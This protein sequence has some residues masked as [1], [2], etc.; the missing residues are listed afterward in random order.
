MANVHAKSTYISIDGNDISAYCNDSDWTRNPDSHDMTVYGDDD[1]VF[2]GGLLAGSSGIGGKYDS[3]TTASPR[4]VLEPL[5]GTV[6]P[7]VYRPEGTGSGLPQRSVNV[8][9]GEYK[10]TAPVANFRMWTCAL[11]HSGAVTRTTQ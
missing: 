11:T 8:F 1:H 4:A 10:E 2:D 5:E 6:V 3:S 9:V 7:M